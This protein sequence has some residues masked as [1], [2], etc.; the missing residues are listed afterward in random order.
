M[1]REIR[2]TCASG[3]ES[4]VKKE[5]RALGFTAPKALDGGISLSGS[6]LDV[7]RLNLFL[8]CADR[9]YLQLC[10]FP[11]KTFDE[12]FDGVSA[13]PFGDVLPFNAQILV[14]GKSK[15]S[16]L[17]ALS[18]CQSIV[19]KAIVTSLSRH[20][21]RKLLPENGEAYRFEFSLV[22]DECTLYLNT[23]GDGLH[24]RG[25]RDLVWE[26]PIKET[27]AAALISFS[28]FSADSPFCDPFCGSGTI[29]IE[30]ARKALGIAPGRDRTFDFIKWD[31]FPRD[32]YDR[33]LQE[34]K[35]GEKPA[36]NP[37][38]FASDVN[39][40]AIDLARRHAQNAGVVGKVRFSVQD[41]TALSLP[42]SGGTIVT[43]P[44]Y[45]ER[46]LD[47][48]EVRALYA[49]F[50]GAYRALDDWSLYLI[51][52]YRDF[53]KFFGRADKK[54]KL[55]NSGIECCLYSYFHTRP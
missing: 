40:K 49:A 43:N 11:A 25:W 8:S 47:Q 48:K 18:S 12:L 15:Q 39:P 13:F 21:K 22:R 16:A 33:A 31:F 36:L 50:A 42:G 3:V 6:D 55:Y 53:E 37:E 9:V 44:P 14:N 1:Q 51:T 24:K 27:L 30:A 23:S 29:A 28:D 38:I 5:L 2:V 20:Y 52:A 7:A 34:A 10:S 26:A 17:F 54:R 35:D 19:K 45:G 4:E 46:L 41:A 32:A